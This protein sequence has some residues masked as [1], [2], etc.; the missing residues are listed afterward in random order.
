MKSF[1]LTV[2]FLLITVTI[3]VFSICPESGC[4]C[5]EY[6]VNGNNIWCR[7]NNGEGCS[8]KTGCLAEDTLLEVG[9]SKKVYCNSCSC[10]SDSSVAACTR[11]LPCFPEGYDY[12][13]LKKV[14][15]NCK[16]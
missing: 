7:D 16:K 14:T 4:G 6:C 9:E 8:C 10:E 11:M 3:H 13:D 2:V 1:C 15:S 5:N 12:P